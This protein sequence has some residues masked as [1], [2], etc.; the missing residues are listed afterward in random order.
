VDQEQKPRERAFLKELVPDWRPTRQQRLWAVRLVIVIVVVLVVLTLLGLPFGISLWDW[1][2]LLVI[3]V[4]IAGGGLWFNAQQREGEQRIANERAQDE[5]LQAYLDQMSGMLIPNKDQPSLS[6]EHPPDSLKTVA[7]ARTLTV[8]TR[9]DGGRKARVVQFLYESDLITKD[10]TIA[11]LEGADLRGA[12]LNEARLCGANLSIVDL[13]GAN[14]SDAKLGQADLSHTNLSGANL[15]GTHLG[16][17]VLDDTNLSQ[18]L[19]SGATFLGSAEL[20]LAE[21]SG[22]DLSGANLNEAELRGANLGG[23]NLRRTYLNLADLTGADLSGADLTGADLSKTRGVARE[24]LAQAVS[25]E[26][27]TMP[28]G[29][30]YEDWNKSREKGGSATPEQRGPWWGG[31]YHRG[32]WRRLFG[33]S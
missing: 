6:D 5:A 1:I 10:R 20:N 28:D 3:P 4:V 31:P 11:D 21:L 16:G 18:V 22:I 7:R 26:G 9:L 17:A 30:K 2:K 29:Q 32:I 23:A 25:L 14:L 13:R 33:G 12:D 24:Q 15:I 8:L 19:S 27:A